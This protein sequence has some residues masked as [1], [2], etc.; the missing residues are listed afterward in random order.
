MEASAGVLRGRKPRTPSP[1]PVQFY[2]QAFNGVG[3]PA[4]LPSPSDIVDIRP[5]SRN[6]ASRSQSASRSHSACSHTKNRMPNDLRVPDV[7][8]PEPV[9]LA[10]KN[11]IIFPR[12]HEDKHQQERHKARAVRIITPRRHGASYIPHATTPMQEAQATQS[13][14]FLASLSLLSF[15]HNL[16]ARFLRIITFSDPA[17]SLFHLGFVTGPQ[18]WL[19]GGWYLTSTSTSTSADMKDAAGKSQLRVW[20]DKHVH[21]ERTGSTGH[22]GDLLDRIE[23]MERAEREQGQRRQGNASS[24]GLTSSSFEIGRRTATDSNASRLHREMVPPA[25]E[26]IGAGVD[27]NFAPD[28]SMIVLPHF[29]SS[30]AVWSASKMGVREYAGH[31]YGRDGASDIDEISIHLE[32]SLWVYRCRIAAFISGLVV[33]SLFISALTVVCVR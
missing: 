17:E 19:L 11:S 29:R 32:Q 4:P 9:Q 21:V 24:S 1:S 10:T 30:R 15:W 6:T 7:P 13:S 27:N 12:V 8:C 22:G 20:V 16:H 26:A 3:P 25:N 23:C 33:M 31:T 18:T 2:T 5:S 14:T 28:T